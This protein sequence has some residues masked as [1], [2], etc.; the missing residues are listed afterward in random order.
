MIT[1]YI[2]YIQFDPNNEINFGVNHLFEKGILS[3]IKFYP[4]KEIDSII[5]FVGDGYGIL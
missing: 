3:N 2:S 1:K 5:E 4:I